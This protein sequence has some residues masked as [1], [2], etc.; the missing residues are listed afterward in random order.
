MV[1]IVE[2]LMIIVLLKKILEYTTSYMVSERLLIDK[3]IPEPTMT[4]REELKEFITHQYR[5][6]YKN[7]IKGR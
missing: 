1:I 5:N 3:G 4:E 7:R 2:I 6:Y